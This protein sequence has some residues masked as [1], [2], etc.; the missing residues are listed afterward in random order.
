MKLQD[1][2]LT[3]QPLKADTFG[4]SVPGVKLGSLTIGPELS[5]GTK[6][7]LSQTT[8]DQEKP[9]NERE[10]LAFVERPIPR[11]LH[12]KVASILRQ[13]QL[14][15]GTVTESINGS[16]VGRVHD[17]TNP[18]NS[19][20]LVTFELEEVSPEDRKFVRPGA[21]FYWTIGVE[22]S[23]AGQ[24]TNIDRIYFRRLP[25]WSASSV[26]EAEQEAREI[27]ALLFSE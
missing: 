14:W 9:A 19:D 20:E 11:D 18:S 26:R 15:E 17:R 1:T 10:F 13:R 22:K 7:S 24:I 4:P 3:G 6:Q 5:A 12:P 21:S 16:F 27:A 2:S 23:P 25:G 8:V